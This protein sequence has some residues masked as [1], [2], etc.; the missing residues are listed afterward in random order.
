MRPI[1]A[2]AFMLAATSA[3]ASDCDLPC[4]MD[5]ALRGDGQA[6][7]DMAQASLY[8]D[9]EIMVNWYRVA[10]ENGHPLG[11]WNYAT[12]LVADS[13]S[14]QDCIRAVYWFD[15][16]SAGGQ[17]GAKEA[18]AQLRLRFKDPKAFEDGCRHAL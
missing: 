10:A 15:R 14:R 6:A 8:Q 9:H 12:W 7:L 16:A 11:Q 2:T 5:K 13:R 1:I 4:K 3:P 17:N 18:A